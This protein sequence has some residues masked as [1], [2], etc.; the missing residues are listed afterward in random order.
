M[1]IILYNVSILCVRLCFLA[2][3]YRIM[4]LKSMRRIVIIVA[5]LVSAWSL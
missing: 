5:G 4:A 1:V 2:Q 3:Y